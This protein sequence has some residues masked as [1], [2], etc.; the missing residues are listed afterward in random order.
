MAELDVDELLRK[1]LER[2]NQADSGNGPLSSGLMNM[3]LAMIAQ[4]RG[5][6]WESLGKGGLLGLQAA[7]AEK[8]REKK[9]PAAM[10]SLLNAVEEYKGNRDMANL[11]KGLGP[12]VSGPAQ[13]QPAPNMPPDVRQQ[14]YGMTSRDDFSPSPNAVVGRP[15]TQPEQSGYMGSMVTPPPQFTGKVPSPQ[16]LMA[17]MA[18]PKRTAAAHNLADMLG[19]KT[20]NVPGGATRF[21]GGQPTYTAPIQTE[22]MVTDASGTSRFVPGWL[23]NK[24]RLKETEAG[25]EKKGQDPYLPPVEVSTGVPGEKLSVSPSGARAIGARNAIPY[26]APAE[27]PAPPAD[28]VPGLSDVVSAYTDWATK[29]G[30]LKSGKRWT[31]D[32]QPP[33]QAPA[34]PPPQMGLNPGPVAEA[35]AQ[36]QGLQQ[37]DLT[38]AMVTDVNKVAID[39]LKLGWSAAQEAAYTIL[40]SVA[41]VK[42]RLAK[43]VFTG[44]GAETKT[45]ILNFVNGW[46]GTDFASSEVAQ[47]QALKGTFGRMVLA[48]MKKMGAVQT[49]ADARRLDEIVG[50]TGLSHQALLEI[51]KVQEKFAN[52]IIDRHNQRIDGMADIYAKRGQPTDTLDEMRVTV[53]GKAPPKAPAAPGAAPEA[54]PTGPLKLN[55]SATAK[56]QSFINRDA[57]FDEIV[58]RMIAQGFDPKY[59]KPK[60]A[61]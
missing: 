29:E 47:S 41:D 50:K 58:R 59:L 32:Y 5:N 13:Y 17:Y 34:A 54:T 35:V 30:G 46:L 23:E 43:G 10:I 4:P 38:K 24:A 26:L 53:E 18:N 3:G 33:P 37:G 21:V 40:P 8:D 7:Q 57:D 19:Y 52:Q 36:Q 2:Y 20:E 6:F 39:N 15:L 25:A 48:D 27:R 49:D 22:G 1:A 9:D 51:A 42:E 44:G 61:K 11:F 14:S 28:S 12:Q 45:A 56:A 55:M 31:F 60:G 16:E